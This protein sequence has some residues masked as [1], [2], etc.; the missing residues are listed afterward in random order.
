M[1]WDVPLVSRASCA[2]INVL[3]LPAGRASVRGGVT[4]TPKSCSAVTQMSLLPPLLL[5]QGSLTGPSFHCLVSMAA[6][7]LHSLFFSLQI[8]VFSSNLP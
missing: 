7:L 5:L 6:V 8:L 4:L 2:V 1:V 3:S